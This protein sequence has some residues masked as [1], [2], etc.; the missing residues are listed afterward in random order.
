[1]TIAPQQ[2]SRYMPDVVISHAH[3]TIDLTRRIVEALRAFGNDVWWDD[4]L[5]LAHATH[6]FAGALGEYATRRRFPTRAAEIV[7]AAIH[8]RCGTHPSS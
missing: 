3:S 8:Q 1:L 5:L 7:P 2:A 6:A 4:E